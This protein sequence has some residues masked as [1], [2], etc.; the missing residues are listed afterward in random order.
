M[1][2]WFVRLISIDLRRELTCINVE[3][4]CF[5]SLSVS[6]RRVSFE[7]YL[8]NL[9]GYSPLTE[10]FLRSSRMLRKSGTQYFIPHPQITQV[11]SFSTETY[12]NEIKRAARICRL[13]RAQ[14]HKFVS[15]VLSTSLLSTLVRCSLGTAP[16]SKHDAIDKWPNNAWRHRRREMNWTSKRRK[17]RSVEGKPW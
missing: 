13:V 16:K 3:K 17:I 11:P 1:T 9:N 15:F 10:K 6:S 4:N 5:F 7:D 12:D 2:A 8:F 14:K